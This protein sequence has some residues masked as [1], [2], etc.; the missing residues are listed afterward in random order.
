[1]TRFRTLSTALLILVGTF[2]AYSPALDGGF[3]WDDDDYVS[4]NETL[5]SAAGL[6]RIWSEIGAVPQY[7]PMVHTSYWLEYRLWGLRTRGYH[8]SNVF[9]HGLCAILLALLLSRLGAPW[10]WLAAALFAFHPVHVESAAWITE[11]KNVLS[12]AFY[13]ASALA[14]LRFQEGP[15]EGRPAGEGRFYALSLG[16]FLCALLSKTV[17]ATLPA[18][19]ALIAWWKR[20]RIGRRD[21]LAL[22]PFLASVLPFCMLT[23]RMERLHV[24]ASGA[25]WSLGV[26]ERLLIAGRASWFYLGKLAWPADLAFIYPRW[27]I[28]PG[29]A[30]QY[31]FPA[32]FLALLALVWMARGRL[33]RGPAAALLYF[34]GTLLPALGFFDFY[35]MRFSFVA[36]HFQY[37]A[38][39]GPLALG[40]SALAL[41]AA[42]HPRLARVL[43]CALL[44][45]LAAAAWRRAAVFSDL[46]TLWRDTL[47]K[48]PACWMAHDNLANLLV[49][50]GRME[51]AVRRYEEA[52]RIKPDY[53]EALNNLGALLFR[54]G[55]LAEA[56]GRLREAARLSPGHAKAHNNLGA[57]LFRRGDVRGAV[58]CFN[59]AL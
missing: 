5:R 45:G 27:E 2:A 11:R 12:G 31:L 57:V 1:M 43:A 4:E 56:E 54:Q 25:G 34:S 39:I 37:L 46:E 33:G 24:G 16:L 9:L 32:A 30:G 58:S 10:P 48:N 23:S 50:N 42:R 28:D 49:K 41:G 38:S 15:G 59:R 29:I 40:A 22:L 14:Y 47:A 6:G 35:P 36:D 55:R 44:L 52:L 13:L 19:L 20:G 7:Y 17:T 3:L 51:E 8:L 18:A 53:P 21:I 26:L